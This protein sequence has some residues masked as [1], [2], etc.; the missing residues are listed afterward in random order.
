MYFFS[1]HTPCTPLSNDGTH[2]T[3]RSVERPVSWFW[4]DI[5]YSEPKWECPFFLY[6]ERIK[7]MEYREEMIRLREVE[8]LTER[9]IAR[10]LELAPSTVH[11]WLAKEEAPPHP[12]PRRG[13]P[14]VTSPTLDQALVLQ[15]T[16]NPFQTAMDIR[17]DFAPHISVDTV[18]KRLKEGGLKCRIPA[19]KPFL[20]EI[21]I[22]KRL[23]FARR[24]FTWSVSDWEKV[25]FSDEKIFRASSKGPLRVYRPEHS[26]RY[27]QEF[28]VPSSNPEGKFT[29]C[30]WMAFGKNFQ[31]MLRVH[32]KTLDSHYYTSVI[33]PSLENHLHEHDLLYMHDR[34]SVHFSLLT[35]R[36]LEAHNIEVMDD[37]P[38]K[39]PDMNPVENVWAE[40]VRRTRNDATNRDQLYE[41][42]YSTFLQLETAY[43]DKLIESMPRR[44]RQVREANG[45]WT[46]Y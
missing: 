1:Y 22:Q 21:H 29:V 13:R 46:K 2:S 30:V 28:L 4:C 39:G 18:R 11:Y 32:Q 20:K 41:N 23:D 26:H 35:Q 45:G 19:R 38:P 8:R 42:V 33:L 3:G 10:L 37:W 36:W 9:Q 16:Q 43:F 44:I 40:L 5:W 14:R 24:Y 27:D 7:H 17:N 6:F 34:S 25:V 12:P 15:S 31:T